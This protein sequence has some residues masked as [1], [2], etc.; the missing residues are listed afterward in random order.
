VRPGLRIVSI[1]GVQH[2]MGHKSV[3]ITLDR[4]GHLFPDELSQLARHLDR[5]YADAVTD[6]ERT[7]AAP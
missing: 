2:R 6:P 3:S 1:K 7:E 4:Y 5:P